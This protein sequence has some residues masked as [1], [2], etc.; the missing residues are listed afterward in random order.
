MRMHILCMLISISFCSCCLVPFCFKPPRFNR[1]S[2]LEMSLDLLQKAIQ[3]EPVE[4]QPATVA[5]THINLA[6]TLLVL[7]QNRAS[8]EHAQAAIV[9]LQGA[10]K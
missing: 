4:A 5:A 7:R 3:N 2:N 9:L 10:H 8:L 6:A 1:S